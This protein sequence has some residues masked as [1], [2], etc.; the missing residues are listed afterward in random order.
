MGNVIASVML[1]KYNTFE[2]LMGS[3]TLCVLPNNIEEY[4]VVGTKEN[5]FWL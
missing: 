4:T 2:L 1:G 3:H 5:V